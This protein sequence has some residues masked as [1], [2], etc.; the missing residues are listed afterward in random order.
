[1]ILASCRLLL[2]IIVVQ[3]SDR[4]ADRLVSILE[5]GSDLEFEAASNALWTLWKIEI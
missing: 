5:A 4:L 2:I 1:L 3:T